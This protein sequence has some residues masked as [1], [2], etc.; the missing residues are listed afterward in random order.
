MKS[1]ALPLVPQLKQLN[2]TMTSACAAHMWRPTL[3][4]KCCGCERQGQ[5]RRLRLSFAVFPHNPS[6]AFAF[7]AV[8]FRGGGICS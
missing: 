6:L 2:A 1:T 4:S 8:Q 3:A 7:R 5:R